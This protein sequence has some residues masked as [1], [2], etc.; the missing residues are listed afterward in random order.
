VTKHLLTALA[1]AAILPAQAQTPAIPAAVA[2]AWARTVMPGQASSGAYMT[3][4][5][6]EPLTLVG[7]VSPAAGIIE[8]HQMKMD[9]D[10]MKMRA[11]DTLELAAGK[12][13]EFKPNGYH[14]MLMDLKAPFRAGTTVPMTLQFR[15]AKGRARE[16]KVSLPVTQAHPV[17][18]RH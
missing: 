16:L 10:V 17:A 5:A 18:H 8:I 7:A 1:F 6:R 15:D 12:A 4:T 14:F 3:L 13:V 11:V 2:G 9:G